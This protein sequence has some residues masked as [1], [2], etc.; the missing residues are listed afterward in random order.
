MNISRCSNNR[1]IG[2][3]DSFYN[4]SH[5]DRAQTIMYLNTFIPDCTFLV[6][7]Q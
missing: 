7:I 6:N 1:S 4:Y 5:N 3:D 2:I